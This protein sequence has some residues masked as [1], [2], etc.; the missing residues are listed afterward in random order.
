MS[1]WRPEDVVVSRRIPVPFGALVRC[2]A[3]PDVISGH[4][5]GAEFDVSDVRPLPMATMVSGWRARATLR[6]RGKRFVRLPAV[7]INVGAWSKSVSE[8]RIFPLTHR[9]HRWGVRRSRRYLKV[10]NGAADSLASRFSTSISPSAPDPQIAKQLGFG[11]ARG[12]LSR[13]G[14]AAAVQTR[15]WTEVF[16]IRRA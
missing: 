9:A 2:L 11:R 10:A 7:E 8:F 15:R 12:R 16:G 1:R 6:R 4:A 14:H 5:F 3:D 13:T